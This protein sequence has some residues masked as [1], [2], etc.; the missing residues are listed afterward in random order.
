MNNDVIEVTKLLISGLKS[1]GTR[2]W[3]PKLCFHENRWYIS[4]SVKKKYELDLSIDVI[5]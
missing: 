3:Y 4:L 1:H 2:V 5:E